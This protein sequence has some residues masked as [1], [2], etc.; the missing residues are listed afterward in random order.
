MQKQT[1]NSSRIKVGIKESDKTRLLRTSSKVVFMK[2]LLGTFINSEN[3]GFA[4]NPLSGKII[5][6]QLDDN[7][8]KKENQNS[9]WKSIGD[10]SNPNNEWKA[11][12]E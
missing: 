1:L 10:C 2:K 7:K 9:L 6:L 5:P 12:F 8:S 4:L 11:L 3:K